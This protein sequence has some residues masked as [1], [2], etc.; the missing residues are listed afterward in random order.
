MKR[1]ARTAI[2]SAMAM[3][4]AAGMLLTPAVANAEV[5]L[6]EATPP[7]SSE[8]AAIV[9]DIPA[10]VPTD[11]PTDGGSAG[12]Q[13]PQPEPSAV[14][15]APA[16]NAT[17]EPTA[18]APNEPG[19]QVL[20][21]ELPVSADGGWAGSPQQRAINEANRKFGP[22]VI[23]LKGASIS[24]SGVIK[25]P[26]RVSAWRNAKRKKRSERNLAAKA[27]K[28]EATLM[29]TN[30]P[31][32]N[33]L[34]DLS[35][36]DPEDMRAFQTKRIKVKGDGV[37]TVVFKVGRNVGKRLSKTAKD[38]LDSQLTIQFV[39]SKDTDPNT[40]GHDTVRVYSIRGGAL[41]KVK[42]TG[43]AR[44]KLV[45]DKRQL[46]LNNRLRAW[47]SD[48]VGPAQTWY[49]YRP[50]DISHL[51]R[52]LDHMAENW[53][54]CQAHQAQ[55][56][57]VWYVGELP[58]VY[59]QEQAAY[60]AGRKA[61]KKY[62]DGYKNSIGKLV[63][64]KGRWYEKEYAHPNQPPPLGYVLDIKERGGHSALTPVG[65]VIKNNTPYQTE[66]THRPLSCVKGSAYPAVKWKAPAELPPGGQLIIDDFTPLSKDVD[67]DGTFKA[68]GTHRVAN[69]LMATYQ[70][71]Y[72]GAYGGYEAM[73]HVKY[74]RNVYGNTQ[75]EVKPVPLEQRKGYSES[76][77]RNATYND[78]GELDVD[79]TRSKV[80]E[81]L[82][83]TEESELGSS[84]V[85]YTAP[86]HT[87]GMFAAYA[88]TEFMFQFL[89]AWR[90]D[91]CKKQSISQLWSVQA[92]ATGLNL[93]N[94]PTGK[95]FGPQS[96][97]SNG[98]INGVR[99]G[100]NNRPVPA[101][102]GAPDEA[103]MYSQL[104]L[105]TTTTWSWNDGDPTT[106][107]NPDAADSSQ[108]GGYTNLGEF[109]QSVNPSQGTIGVSWLGS[110]VGRF[111]PY[112]AGTRV[113]AIT[114]FFP[115][116]Q[117]AI[118]A[119]ALRRSQDFGG[120]ASLYCDAGSWNFTSPWTPTGDSAPAASTSIGEIVAESGGVT[121]AKGI[122]YNVNFHA[123]DDEG[124]AL[125]GLGYTP[126]DG[127]PGLG[128][129]ATAQTLPAAVTHTATGYLTAK[130][131]KNLVYKDSSGKFVPY[132][133]DFPKIFGCT[134]T[135]S[136]S[137]PQGM[138]S[139]GSLAGVP[140][141]NSNNYQWISAPFRADVTLGGAIEPG[142]PSMIS[143][144]S[145]PDVT[146][147][148][149]SS[150]VAN[151][152]DWT[153]AEVP[154]YTW[155]WCTDA[156]CTNP[157]QDFPAGISG[158]R[159]HKLDMATDAVFGHGLYLRVK[160]VATN[161]KNR[162][163]PAYSNAV[164]MDGPYFVIAGTVECTGG[165]PAVNA[166]CSAS[167]QIYGTDQTLSY[168]WKQS[169]VAWD[170]AS[171]IDPKDLPYQNVTGAGSTSRNITLK[172][173]MVT[174]GHVLAVAVRSSGMV[175][176][177]ADPVM[178]Y[179]GQP[180]STVVSNEVPDLADS[181]DAAPR[182]TERETQYPTANNHLMTSGGMWKQPGTLVRFKY[183]E[184][185]A[186]APVNN[187]D[188][189]GPWTCSGDT[190]ELAQSTYLKPTVD[191][192]Y[193][194]KI[195]AGVGKYFVS[196]VCG[197]LQNPQFENCVAGPG[198]L[199]YT[200]QKPQPR[201]FQGEPFTDLFNPYLRPTLAIP[202]PYEAGYGIPKQFGEFDGY[203][204][205]DVPLSDGTSTADDR[206]LP[207]YT[208]G[209]LVFR[210]G[211]PVKVNLGNWND[212]G[213]NLTLYVLKCGTDYQPGLP[214]PFPA[215]YG[216]SNT[217]GYYWGQTSGGDFWNEFSGGWV[218]WAGCRGSAEVVYQQGTKNLFPQYSLY[219]NPLYD[220]YW[221]GSDGW[222]PLYWPGPAVTFEAWDPG[223]PMRY[224]TRVCGDSGN[225]EAQTCVPGP[226]FSFM[227]Q[228]TAENVTPPSAISRLSDGTHFSLDPGE[229]VSDSGA[230]TNYKVIVD[231]CADARPIAD[232]DWDG[233]ME[234]ASP[235]QASKDI[236]DPLPA[237]KWQN[238]DLGYMNF[239]DPTVF[240]TY[241]TPSD[242]MSSWPKSGYF[243][244][245]LWGSTALNATE[246]RGGYMSTEKAFLVNQSDLNRMGHMPDGGWFVTRVCGIV[247]EGRLGQCVP[248]PGD[249]LGMRQAQLV[250]EHGKDPALPLAFSQV[251]DDSGITVDPSNVHVVAPAYD[252]EVVPIRIDA[253]ECSSGA[254]DHNCAGGTMRHLKRDY[255]N[256]S[257]QNTHY[258]SG[259]LAK[260][261]TSQMFAISYNWNEDPIGWTDATP[262]PVVG[263]KT[264]VLKYPKAKSEVKIAPG[265]SISVDQGK[266]SAR[267]DT[268]ASFVVQQCAS[269]SRRTEVAGEGTRVGD[270]V[271]S[272][273]TEQLEKTTAQPWS[274]DPWTFDVPE[275]ALRKWL[276]TSMCVSTSGDPNEVCYFASAQAVVPANE[277]GDAPTLDAPPT[278]VAP[279]NGAA[280]EL[281]GDVSV[282]AGKWVT[283]GGA[284][285][286]QANFFSCD[287]VRLADG[288]EGGNK[289]TSPLQ[290]VDTPVKIASSD[291][292]PL[293]DS[294]VLTATVETHAY[295]VVSQICVADSETHLVVTCDEGPGVGVSV[296]MTTPLEKPKTTNTKAFT[297]FSY[298]DLMTVNAG[299]WR[300][301]DQTRVRVYAHT[302]GALEEPLEG[303]SEAALDDG[304][305]TCVPETI[306]GSLATNFDSGWLDGDEN[307]SADVPVLLQQGNAVGSYMATTV[308]AYDVNNPR[309]E[310]SRTC[311]PGP[312]RYLA[313]LEQT[314]I[315]APTVVGGMPGGVV[316][317]DL[318]PIDPG[319]WGTGPKTQITATTVL[320]PASEVV[321][322]TDAGVSGVGTW[323][324]SN[325]CPAAAM[326]RGGSNS[327]A[328]SYGEFTHQVTAQDMEDVQGD[329][330]AFVEIVGSHTSASGLPVETKTFYSEGV[331]I[332]RTP[333]P[334]TYPHQVLHNPTKLVAGVDEVTVVQSRWSGREV[335]VSFETWECDASVVD[336]NECVSGGT[337]KAST[338]YVPL[339]RGQTVRI[340]AA[341]TAGKNIAIRQCAKYVDGAGVA[342]QVQSFGPTYAVGDVPDARNSKIPTWTKSGGGAVNGLLSKDETVVVNTGTWGAQA[343]QL[344]VNLWYCPGVAPA[345]ASKPV[346]DQADCVQPD[347]TVQPDSYKLMWALKAKSG[348]SLAF[349][350]SG[351]LGSLRVNPVF[352]PYD[353]SADVKADTQGNRL[354]NGYLVVEVCAD[355]TTCVA[356]PSA[357]MWD[358]GSSP[359]VV[360]DPKT[361]V[362]ALSGVSTEMVEGDVWVID[363]GRWTRGQATPAD[364]SQADPTMKMSVEAMP[365]IQSGGPLQAGQRSGAA[366]CSQVSSNGTWSTVPL[367]GGATYDPSKA[368][369]RADTTGWAPGYYQSRVC[370]TPTTGS[371][372]KTCAPGPVAY[373]AGQ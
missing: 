346:R 185:D 301:G 347:S 114:E 80:K 266:W 262:V 336:Q 174:S 210:P 115:Q 321:Q 278:L 158:Q 198:V 304:S 88:G 170:P 109:T 67:K 156:A 144:P 136:L 282:T 194:Q 120:G 40:V 240:G 94:Q 369:A 39:N 246:T 61:C 265:D 221:D 87:T 26:V 58:Y 234:C 276:V 89:K 152:G 138:G 279:T 288:Y 220:E 214:N 332:T 102:W 205:D 41:K 116:F 123:Y 350:I 110:N 239:N 17:G 302:C 83:D 242:P 366:L 280:L 349:N 258:R 338:D 255:F 308:C 267:E 127:A 207:T 145:I 286:V 352:G 73:D 256:W 5:Q 141:F 324:G 370:A 121:A 335:N 188:L 291:W 284:L 53:Q 176:E 71:F 78:K 322:A 147:I 159:T 244:S 225:P 111:G 357:R 339:E 37:A 341:V 232:G 21:S 161:G 150:V 218:D 219:D 96:W 56:Q 155:Q 91:M 117:G 215:T 252:D 90:A 178:V 217:P 86:S 187:N 24:R 331:P 46:S 151:P 314:V 31:I 97:N 4:V 135:A 1:I 224:A 99:V 162:S 160:V 168:Q 235:V 260:P 19:E 261:G 203:A 59:D 126:S 208:S 345:S 183:F 263:P 320:C 351:Y 157:K 216:G 371:A 250:K 312:A 68:A 238:D 106:G 20:G 181:P 337:K 47:H 300:T 137:V 85:T 330:V 353:N 226:T 2:A 43:S 62:S 247:T 153:T 297:E 15:S 196:Q 364:G 241:A 340:P 103:H 139:Q 33:A 132:K 193:A 100:V 290:C 327:H 113:Q 343:G 134:V 79:K 190:K 29:L 34:S 212:P 175:T 10:A 8:P 35:F 69:L 272:G 128:P 131:A 95:P 368:K 245:A 52:D 275:S 125:Y 363:Y 319:Q 344:T 3:S 124:H 355:N 292:Q 30:S 36:V 172:S 107:P 309:G 281:P 199:V 180:Y 74:G 248:G 164:P 328:Q 28:L 204:F 55:P 197:T 133:G 14:P 77:E 32:W 189:D 140:N 233:A 11:S 296:P 50:P 362:P 213:S 192:S 334:G 75:G 373:V 112:P 311:V 229:W 154:E 130:Q 287:T 48:Y 184:C 209:N 264:Y 354:I 273:T 243:T 105:G 283:S 271:C 76:W 253:Y 182:I 285:D 270:I 9:E 251:N 323:Q 259:Y 333:T 179:A 118:K 186:A 57:P 367:D 315:Q 16:D 268:L 277:V 359:Y 45:L 365:C 342:C 307:G 211:D 305:F 318:I 303:V 237:W 254:P 195:T 360:T 206:F 358:G 18:S 25:V 82:K 13:V 249:P 356:G 295:H 101:G 171:N 148:P 49:R 104:A 12:D 310:D 313:S 177:N 165:K 64:A 66:L 6:A 38:A 293:T 326:W 63:G 163:K 230:D 72:K 306:N 236:L 122:G 231:F 65:L 169:T 257:K 81:D 119:A 51:H 200:D 361:T 372:V 348:Q 7:A 149:G 167:P 298:L 27:D 325:A 42:S 191:L 222:G 269:V 129:N 98:V 317:G 329:Y 223:T 92:M 70:S 202:N 201:E 54:A 143:A 299:K 228:R 22:G 166:I 23:P 274:N 227:D 146:V 84:A 44:T 294:S 142:V 289:K 173:G 60:E 316:Q 93:N 108:S